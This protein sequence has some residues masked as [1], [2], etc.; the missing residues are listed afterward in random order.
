MKQ[1]NGETQSY[2]KK[3]TEKHT[4]TRLKLSDLT[5]NIVTSQ[6]QSHA[7]ETHETESNWLKHSDSYLWP[8]T[9][10]SRVQDMGVSHES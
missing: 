6:T 7:N 2:I 10:E 1:T 3:K 8:T 4:W 5:P 9:H